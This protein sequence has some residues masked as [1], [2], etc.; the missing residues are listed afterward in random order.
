MRVSSWIGIALAAVWV[1]AAS[2][3][4][5]FYIDG[6][7]RGQSFTRHGGQIAN[8]KSIYYEE[9]CE[10]ERSIGKDGEID[11]PYWTTCRYSF[12]DT[13]ESVEIDGSESVEIFE[14]R[15]FR[16]DSELLDQGKGCYGLGPLW[17]IGSSIKIYR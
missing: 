4:V 11:I 2:A 10:R 15:N 5:T 9:P 7:C 14:H 17:N 3:D 13:I 16:G 6:D 1:T 8:L 12:N